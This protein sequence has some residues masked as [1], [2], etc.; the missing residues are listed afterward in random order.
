M[1]FTKIPTETSEQLSSVLNI[2]KKMTYTFVKRK[3]FTRC[4]PLSHRNCLSLITEIPN[5]CDAAFYM[6]HIINPLQTCQW[7]QIVFLLFG[8]P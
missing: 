6:F 7:L 3:K 4:Q 2:D 5:V 8:A 1:Y